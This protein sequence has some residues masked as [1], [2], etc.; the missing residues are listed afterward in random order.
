MSVPSST[1]DR[2]VYK[3]LS[4]EDRGLLV[5]GVW[6][7]S[8]PD[9][10]V[11]DPT[12]ELLGC[13]RVLKDLGIGY[14]PVPVT[15]VANVIAF[16]FST[17]QGPRWIVQYPWIDDPTTDFDDTDEYYL[18]E[19]AT[20]AGESWPCLEAT[21]TEGGSLKI[22]PDEV[23]PNNELGPDLPYDHVVCL[24]HGEVRVVHPEDW[25]E[26]DEYDE[27]DEEAL[28]RGEV[29]ADDCFEQNCLG[30]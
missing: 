9:G 26:D 29:H 6:Y 23:D 1:T 28:D 15:E 17:P 20:F 7:F 25:D 12:P 13:L 22:W 5:G 30:C 14:E 10:T 3:P 4:E 8:D 16:R 18:F 21:V 2:N 24:V 27:S 11:I 19:V